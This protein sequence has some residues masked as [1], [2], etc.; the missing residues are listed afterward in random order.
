MV[1]YYT[2]LY[3]LKLLKKL[4]QQITANNN[5]GGKFWRN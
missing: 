1:E 4:L 5:N 2:V 3:T